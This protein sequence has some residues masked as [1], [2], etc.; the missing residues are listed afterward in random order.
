MFVLG[1]PSSAARVG[2]LLLLLAPLLAPHAAAQGANP[3][4]ARASTAVPVPHTLLSTFSGGIS[5]GAYQA[6]V[7]WAIME[8]VRTSQD[9]P[10]FRVGHGLRELHFG[11]AAG[12]SAGNINAIMW[13]I[14]ACSDVPPGRGPEE[15]LF[16]KTW[17][18]VGIEQLL[19]P[20]P[21]DPR[22]DEL[23]LLDREFFDTV[24]T[25]LQARIA[26]TEFRP[27][28]EMPVGITLTRVLPDTQHLK[29]RLEV[30]TQRF[31]TVLTARTASGAGAP[32]LPAEPRDGGR[33]VFHPVHPG[34]AL[35]NR[36]GRVRLAARDSAAPIVTDSLFRIVRAS[37]A[38]P[39]AFAPMKLR[40]YNPHRDT[41]E[42]ELFADGGLF[43]NNPIDVA[44]LM[45]DWMENRNRPT[46]G[47]KP[48]PPPAQEPPAAQPP[49]RPRQLL[50]V[51]PDVGRRPIEKSPRSLVTERVVRPPV[52]GGLRSVAQ[53]LSGSVTAAREYELTA[54][55]RYSQG[56]TGF[57]VVATTRHYPLIGERMG[58]FA[59]FLNRGFREYDFYVGAYDALF[60]LTEDSA[61]TLR[62]A[63]GNRC[64]RVRWMD[65]L[66][67]G[68][69][70]PPHGR[71]FIRGL[72]NDELDC[73]DTLPPLP[74]TAD[75]QVRLGFYRLTLAA[76]DAAPLSGAE[77]SCGQRSVPE[78][79]LCA[80]DMETV[81]AAVQMGLE[82]LPGYAAACLPG[83]GLRR[84][85]PSGAWEEL[86]L[87]DLADAPGTRMQEL[88]E[89]V[90]ARMPAMEREVMRQ[91]REND[92]TAHPSP[93]AETGSELA[94]L[95]YYWG[96]RPVAHLQ[97][98]SVPIDGAWWWLI[99]TYLSTDGDGSGMEAGWQP[100]YYLPSSR[101]VGVGLTGALR[102]NWYTDRTGDRST[103]ETTTWGTAVLGPRLTYRATNAMGLLFSRV[104]AS[105]LA[106]THGP[107]VEAAV[108][109]FADRLRVAARAVAGGREL[110]DGSDIVL[111]FGLN[112]LPGLFYWG[113]KLTGP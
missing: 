29:G 47:G 101:G 98:G 66:A 43:D 45:Q 44:N 3:L 38:F 15:S 49:S 91:E 105:V 1:K 111:T 81:L 48:L 23:A 55:D 83:G 94:G 96:V 60:A 35:L 57:E 76:Q 113:S 69:G 63:P 50:Y 75:G 90:L 102:V 16:W 32:P 74:V 5:L 79:I 37:S 59:A 11:A 86:E 18:P 78:W 108:G 92:S 67:A 12:A 89:R 58:A 53:M 85:D 21:F 33:F 8:A 103:W 77:R 64:S 31:V 28:C 88:M 70:T 2:L 41:T 9:E 54:L 19:R 52:P 99:P 93:I 104:D 6:G 73:P 100:T 112:D 36:L 80:G 46:L 26:R 97:S 17:M 27:A 30:R 95:L 34:Q 61:F 7:N 65:T 25:A 109:L 22:R 106:S 62:K 87:C 14:E 39:V 10:R 68:I 110:A 84:R 51:D 24:Q 56:R 71:A 4:R 72:A 40:L 13:A 20:P 107:M 82:T 42:L